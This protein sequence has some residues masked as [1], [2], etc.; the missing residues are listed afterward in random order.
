MYNQIFSNFRATCVIKDYVSLDVELIL[1]VR[2][3][4]LVATVSVQ[5]PACQDQNHVES[6]HYV[7]SPIIEQFVCV[8]KVTKGNQVRNV[9]NWNAIVT[10]IAIRTSTAASLVFA[11]I[12]V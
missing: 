11:Q 6:T 2:I 1:T 5:I 9:I 7:E 4:C 3:C 12:H 10:K 8:R